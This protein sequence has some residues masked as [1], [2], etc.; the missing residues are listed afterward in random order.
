MGGDELVHTVPLAVLDNTILDIHYREGI[1]FIDAHEHSPTTEVINSL[2]N[3]RGRPL[4]PMY[5]IWIYSA[6][7]IYLDDDEDVFDIVAGGFSEGTIMVSREIKMKTLDTGINDGYYK[8]F[9]SYDAN[10]FANLIDLR[11]TLC[12]AGCIILNYN[13]PRLEKLTL[14]N[15]RDDTF[16]TS[17]FLQYLLSLHP[18][19]PS[20]L[21]EL[22]FEKVPP[23][24]D[25]INFIESFMKKGGIISSVTL[26]GLPHPTILEVLVRALRN[27]ALDFSKLTSNMERAR[28][29]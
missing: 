21:K 3:V 16:S 14:T 19:G 8:T 27:E 17:S 9:V 20:Q 4:L 18:R 24:Q 26:C 28:S 22:V 11:C 6:E 15:H 25:L 2:A 7:N 23:W 5:T 12:V 29:I 13:T 1:F 10:R